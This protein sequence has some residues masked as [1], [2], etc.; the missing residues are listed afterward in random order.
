MIKFNHTR[1]RVNH[2]FTFWV[3]GLY[4]P[5]FEQYM[6]ELSKS[7]AEGNSRFLKNFNSKA[8]T[9]T[10]GTGKNMITKFIREM[11]SILGIVNT[12]GYTTHCFRRSAATN[13]ADAGVSLVNLKR[14]GQ[15]KSDSVAERYIANSVPI[16]Q[17]RVQNLLPN[18][19]RN[20]ELPRSLQNEFSS[21]SSSEGS[22]DSPIKDLKR[23]PMTTTKVVPAVAQAPKTPT[24]LEDQK[25]PAQPP[26]NPYKK[27]KTVPVINVDSSDD[28]EILI[29]IDGTPIKV[30]ANFTQHLEGKQGA[31]FHNCTFVFQDNKKFKENKEE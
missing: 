17:E 11:C 6:L 19:L 4:L 26:V 28:D 31:T 3:P 18:H 22:F 10:I 25:P 14:H 16:R 5:M 24:R 27:Q 8:K 9:R 12:V 23:P 29:S 7:G 2:G 13:L 15:W 1:K 21:S 30:P 20:A